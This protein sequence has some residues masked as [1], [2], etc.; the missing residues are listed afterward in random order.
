MDLR[1]KWDYGK[2]LVYD[3]KRLGRMIGLQRFDGVRL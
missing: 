2:S 1:F 3:T